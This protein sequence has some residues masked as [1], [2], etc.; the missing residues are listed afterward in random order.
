[1]HLFAGLLRREKVLISHF[2][3]QSVMEKTDFRLT[4]IAKSITSGWVYVRE[5]TV[6]DIYLDALRATKNLLRAQG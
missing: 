4:G 3:A 2:A 5:S 6:A 1:M